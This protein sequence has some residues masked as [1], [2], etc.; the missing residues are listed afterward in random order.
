MSKKPIEAIVVGQPTKTKDIIE[1][2]ETKT[3]H[4]S[5]GYKP[6]TETKTTIKE[7]PVAKV[8]KTF[9]ITEHHLAKL[10][11]HCAANNK[12]HSH[13]LEEAIDF[14]IPD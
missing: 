5:F 7:R 13:W 9:N 10:R 2:V 1:E 11:I 6:T 3:I 12:K 14:L 8:K 4:H